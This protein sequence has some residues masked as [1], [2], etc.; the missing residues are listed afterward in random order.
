MKIDR[1]KLIYNYDFEAARTIH[2]Y[3]MRVDRQKLKK[4]YEIYKYIYNYIQI[5]IYI[6]IKIRK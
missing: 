5:N 1:Q 6:Y 3:E 2:S 4:N